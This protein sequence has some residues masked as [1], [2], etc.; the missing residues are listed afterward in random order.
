[1]TASVK[2]S[3]AI[4]FIESLR[5]ENYYKDFK[6]ILLKEYLGIVEKVRELKL[7]QILNG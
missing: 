2:Y 5:Y 3:E 1:M 7:N 6:N 4:G